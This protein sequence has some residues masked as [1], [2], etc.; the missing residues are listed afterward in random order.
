MQTVVQVTKLISYKIPL[1]TPCYILRLS[2]SKGHECFTHLLFRTG[3]RMLY[4]DHIYRFLRRL[5]Q[6]MH[7]ITCKSS[8]VKRPR[9]LCILLAQLMSGNL[10]TICNYVL[11]MCSLKG[12][13]VCAEPGHQ[14]L[15]MST[16]LCICC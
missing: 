9:E 15:A 12:V 10:V 11:H 14:P 7:I 6:N 16:I 2:T 5:F 1:L 13:H 4:N 8:T 3:Q